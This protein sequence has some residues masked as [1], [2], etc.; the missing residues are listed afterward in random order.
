MDVA[1]ERLKGQAEIWEHI[2]AFVDSMALKCVVELGIPNIINSHGRPVTIS[3][4]IDSLKTATSSPNVD[5]LTHIMRLLVHKHL[6]TSQFHQESNQTVYGLTRSSKWLLKDSEFNLSPLVLVENSP[7]LQK[8][9]QYLGKC[10]QENGLPFERAHGCGIWDLALVDPEFNKCFNGAMQSMTIMIINEMLTEYR[11]GLNGIGSLVDVGGGTGTMIAEIVKANP[12][13]QGINFDLPHVVSTA[14]EFSGVKHVGGDMFV[15]IPEADAVIMKSLLHDWTDE[16]CAK[17]LRNCYN[18]ITNKKNGKVI[19]VEVVL[20]PEGSG[21]FD[22]TGLIL[23]MVMM[24]HTSGGKERTE[25]EWK[26]LLNSAGFPRY[27]I[28]QTPACPCIIEAF[29][30]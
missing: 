12:H 21:V 2:F 18:A 1:E 27:N 9:W 8:P 26:M 15:H 6:F 10:F 7:I 13:V 29:P 4:I 11:D 30:E 3:E 17:I 20:R 24:A 14:P 22:K 16:D 28:I 23:D 5:Y 19:I 25:V